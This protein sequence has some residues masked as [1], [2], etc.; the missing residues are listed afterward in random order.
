MP[1]GRR[2]AKS[3]SFKHHTHTSDD[4]HSMDMPKQ[5][6]VIPPKHIPL[7]EFPPNSDL[8]FEF[9]S[10]ILSIFAMGGQYINLYRSVFWLPYSHTEYALNWYLIDYYVVGISLIMMGRRLPVCLLKKLC[11]M[12]FPASYQSNCTLCVHIFTMI[13]LISLLFYFFYNVIL[14]HGIVSAV[15]LLYPFVV[16]AVVM[17]PNYKKFLELQSAPPPPKNT[18]ARS[19]HSAPIRNSSTVN[20][21]C[22]MSAETIREEVEMLRTDFNNRWK[23]VLFNTFVVVY[24]ATFLPCFFSQSQLQYDVNWATQHGVL[25]GFSCLTLYI[26]HCFPP[27]YCDVLHR[28]ALHL[29][30]WQRVEIKNVHIPYS[31]WT[32]TSM[33]NQGALVKHSKELFKAEG[34]SNAAEPGHSGHS[35]FYSLFKNPSIATRLVWIVQLLLIATEMFILMQSHTWNDLI[36]LQLLIMINCKTLYGMTKVYFVVKK[37]YHEESILISKFT[38]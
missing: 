36:S 21:V 30:R 10:L 29:G 3:S 38:S 18:G 4:R 8:E 22:S 5:V 37:I 23:Q 33:W 32:E 25:T 2:N 7:P 35:K 15:F 24:H 1:G 31:M 26:A 28:A 12:C 9:D 20:H 19:K 13:T 16:Y 17:G 27:K 6:K 14:E 34:I 11:K